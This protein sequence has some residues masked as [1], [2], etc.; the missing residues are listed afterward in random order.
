DRGGGGM[1]HRDS[2]A[3]FIALRPGV[4][5]VASVASVTAHEFFHAWNV[6]R[7]RPQGLEPIDYFRENYTTA[8][9]FSEGVTSYYGDLSLRRGGLLSRQD[10]LN[11]LS[12]E[13]RTLQSRPAHRTQSAAES[14]LMTWYDKYG[15]YQQSDQS[16]SYYNKGELIGL[17]LDL[18]IRD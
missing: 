18:K 2:T 11:A 14:S 10:Y 9:W 17:L 12:S 15:F 5:S 4:R 13:I 1:E 7:I 6:K 8:L 16:I 3:I